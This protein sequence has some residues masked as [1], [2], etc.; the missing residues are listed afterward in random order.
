MRMKVIE[1]VRIMFGKKAREWVNK[2][3]N[4]IYFIHRDIYKKEVKL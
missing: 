3:N 1:I 2:N 4:D